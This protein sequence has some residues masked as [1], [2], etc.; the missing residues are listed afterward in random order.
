MAF[1]YCFRLSDPDEIQ[2]SPYDATKAFKDQ[3][4]KAIQSIDTTGWIIHRDNNSYRG[5]FGYLNYLTHLLRDE[6]RTAN[7]AVWKD[8]PWL[9]FH[10][11]ASDQLTLI[12]IETLYPALSFLCKAALDMNVINDL[13]NKLR[14]VDLT[15]P[16]ARLAFEVEQCMATTSPK[17][18]TRYL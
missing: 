18:I 12:K 9:T 11:V 8:M 13:C 14:K 6:A 16:E 17:L 7:L 5:K 4:I 2:I 1:Y 15:D 3:V 10:G